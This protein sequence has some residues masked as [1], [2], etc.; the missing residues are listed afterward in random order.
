M[1]SAAWVRQQWSRLPDA[2][3]AALTSA[4]HDPAPPFTTSLEACAG[5]GPFLRRVISCSG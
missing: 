3:A 2:I 4:T 1:V 5:A